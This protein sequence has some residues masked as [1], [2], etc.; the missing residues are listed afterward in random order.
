M[1]VP[2]SD[3]F[4]IDGSETSV[5]DLKPG[6]KLTETKTNFCARCTHEEYEHQLGRH[7]VLADDG[8]V[9]ARR[10]RLG[11]LP[12]VSNSP[13]SGDSGQRRAERHAEGQSGS[14]RDPVAGER[15]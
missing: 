11:P 10:G 1:I 12:H 9:R 13:G 3:K 2:D 8:E 7:I 14:L 6:T 4:H 15:G 5:Y